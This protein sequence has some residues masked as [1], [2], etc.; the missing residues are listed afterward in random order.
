VQTAFAFLIFVGGFVALFVWYGLAERRW[1]ADMVARFGWPTW[2]AEYMEHP[3]RMPPTSVRWRALRTPSHDSDLER[4]RLRVVWR[5]K[6]WLG[7]FAI[8]GVVVG[9]VL[10]ATG[11]RPG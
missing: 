9:L 7:W 8:G 5:L 4:D 6:L 2:T 11:Q 3:E 1:W 10:L